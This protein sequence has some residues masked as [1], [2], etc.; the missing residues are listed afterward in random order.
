MT[1]DQYLEVN[2]MSDADFA[3]AIKADRTTV[4]RL[5]RGAVLPEWGTMRRIYR[6]TSGLVTPTDFL[7]EAAQ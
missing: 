1:L 6:A 7:G 4:S 2:G 3:A 5:R